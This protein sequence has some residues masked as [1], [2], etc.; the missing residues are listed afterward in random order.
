MLAGIRRHLC[1]SRSVPYKLQR[2]VW[3][4]VVY[5]VIEVKVSIFNGDMRRGREA[6]ERVKY[7]SEEFA[8]IRVR[9]QGP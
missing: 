3:G 2:L 8:W 9:N 7:K 6:R 1:T 5:S 4:G